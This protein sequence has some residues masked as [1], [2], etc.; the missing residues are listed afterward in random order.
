M[1]RM[2]LIVAAISIVAVVAVVAFALLTGSAGNKNPTNGVQSA[3]GSLR[4]GEEVSPHFIATVIKI[5]DRTFRIRVEPYGSPRNVY[6]HPEGTYME[7]LMFDDK[8]NPVD[9]DR[10]SPA[11]DTPASGS[12]FAITVSRYQPGPAVGPE[13]SVL[14]DERLFS[15]DKRKLPKG[16]YTISARV[17]V[18]EAGPAAKAGK[19][20]SGAIATR[21]RG[22]YKLV[23]P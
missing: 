2:M 5:D 4:P 22:A 23:I 17:E 6:I 12:D 20:L 15:I 3:I 10:R 8:G 16:V 21:V 13:K 9:N 18:C 11:E 14:Q 19:L 1:R 7:P